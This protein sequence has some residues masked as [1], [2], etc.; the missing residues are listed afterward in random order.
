MA[1]ATTA[2]TF[3]FTDT[4]QSHP[5]NLTNKH[6]VHT[7]R[8]NKNHKNGG[9]DTARHLL[10]P[11]IAEDE[12][13]CSSIPSHY[14]CPPA[15]LKDAIEF[16]L[17]VGFRRLRY[18]FLNKE[19]PFWLETILK[20]ALQYKNVSF[21][22][23]DRYDDQIGLDQTSSTITNDD[24]IGA[25]KKTNYVLSP[26]K[27]ILVSLSSSSA[28]SSRDSR[29]CIKAIETAEISAYNDYYFS[30]KLSTSTPDVPFGRRFVAHTQMVLINTG[31]NRCKLICSVDADFP[32]GGEPP[33]GIG[34]QIRKAMKNASMETF[35]KIRDAI[36]VVCAGE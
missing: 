8:D 15:N 7:Y 34:R 27:T 4:K 28:A 2:S 11:K 12:K 36:M 1:S 13:E 18:A 25:T 5:F 23:W 35:K 30:L 14:N 3:K 26:P 32:N 6:L 9:N 21:T 33:L 31:K 17:P 29:G 10:G 20:G 24:F 16:D 19:S 22:E